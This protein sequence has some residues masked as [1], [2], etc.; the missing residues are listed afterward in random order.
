MAERLSGT[1]EAMV[2]ADRVRA[3]GVEPRAAMLLG[4]ALASREA[5]AEIVYYALAD[6]EDRITRAPAAVAVFYT[7]RGRLV[8][9][10]SRSPAGVLWTTLK[11]GS[12]HAAGQAIGALI[13]LSG[14]RW[15]VC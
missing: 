3:L 7:R 5:F 11:P 10:P 8:S 12:D 6:D 14:E 2:L 4:S 1:R 9:A 13:E 15:G